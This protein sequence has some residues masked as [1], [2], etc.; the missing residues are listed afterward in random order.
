MIPLTCLSV[1]YLSTNK[2][3][4]IKQLY[5]FC[6]LFCKVVFTK[7]SFFSPFHPYFLHRLIRFKSIPLSTQNTLL[8]IIISFWCSRV[9]RVYLVLK[10]RSSSWV[11]H[12]L[13]FTQGVSI[14]RHHRQTHRVF[15]QIIAQIR[16]SMVGIGLKRSSCKALSLF[17]SL[18]DR[19]WGT[20]VLPLVPV[21]PVG[22]T[23][24][25]YSNFIVIVGQH[26]LLKMAE[27]QMRLHLRRISLTHDSFGTD[28]A[29]LTCI[30]IRHSLCNMLLS[31]SLSLS[32]SSHVL[33]LKKDTL[34]TS[35]T[36]IKRWEE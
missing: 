1:S 28:W 14:T 29:V 16:P 4:R 7:W 19:I 8:M 30:Q 11:Y 24:Q 2:T 27:D 13:L 32:L 25:V 17:L 21:I 3:R 22:F 33:V 35:E 15:I 23:T 26:S 6:I 10:G 5:I 34:N 18:R 36:S 20:L 12:L 31:L 9:T